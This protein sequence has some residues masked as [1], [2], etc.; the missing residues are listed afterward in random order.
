MYGENETKM[1]KKYRNEKRRPTI[2][3]KKR[4]IYLGPCSR[5][6]LDSRLKK[7]PLNNPCFEDLK[8]FE[9][10]KTYYNVHVY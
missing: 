10:L 6:L 4:N 7:K 1:P 8:I 2:Q 9:D 5:V 3:K